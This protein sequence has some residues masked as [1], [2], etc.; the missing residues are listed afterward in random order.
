[1][2]MPKIQEGY[3]YNP[4]RFISFSSTLDLFHLVLTAFHV[5]HPTLNST[6]LGFAFS[7]IFLVLSRGNISWNMKK[8]PPYSLSHAPVHAET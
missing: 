2:Y 6:F 8:T 3:A 5:S 7:I 4:T 1:M